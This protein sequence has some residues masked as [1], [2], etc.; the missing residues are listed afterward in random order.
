MALADLKLPP[1]TFKKAAHYTAGRSAKVIA[2]V[3]HRMV[4]T[5]AG[6]DAYFTNPETRQVSTHFGIG[7][8]SDGKVGISQYVPLDDTAYGN[9][10][11]DPSGSWDNWGYAT[12]NINAQTISIEHQDHDGT[13]AN[14]GIVKQEVQTASQKLQTLLRFGT[15]EQWKAAGIV[16]RSWDNAKT[17]RAELDLIPVDGRHIITHN[18]IAGKLKPYCWKPWEKDTIGFPRSLYLNQIGG[19]LKNILTFVAPVP[20]PIQNVTM[21]TDEMQAM[22][23]KAFAAGAASRDTEVAALNNQI[24]QLNTNVLV[25]QGD[26]KRMATKL[27]DIGVVLDRA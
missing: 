8:R 3:N 21:T 9:G 26:N 14:K 5:L 6:T 15:I 1:I 2:F 4:G 17:I 23:D 27:V 20:A 7:F 25:L 19:T 12:V 16:F 10:N 22:L 18:D 24:T 11:Y 13:L